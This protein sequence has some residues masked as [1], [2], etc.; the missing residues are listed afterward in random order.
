MR[1]N[2]VPTTFLRSTTERKLLV[3]GIV[4]DPRRRTVK[5]RCRKRPVRGEEEGGGGGEGGKETI[6]RTTLVHLFVLVARARTR[7]G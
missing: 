7:K 6:E 2:Y 1:E 5:S 4:R 3:R